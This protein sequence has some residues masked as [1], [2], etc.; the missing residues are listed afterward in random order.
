MEPQELLHQSR[1]SAGRLRPLEW[2]A[3]VVVIASAL[4]WS[5][6][7]TVAAQGR[8]GTPALEQRIA[9][10]EAKVAALEAATSLGASQIAALQAALANEVTARRAADT[11]LQSSIDAEIAVRQVGDTTLQTNIDAEA[12][13]RRAADTGLQTTTGEFLGAIEA[14]SRARESEDS[15]L[16]NRAAALENKTQYISVAGGDMFITGTN[17]NI[18]NGLGATNGNPAD[19]IST[20]PA[21]THVNGK[22]NL[23]VGYNES[24]TPEGSHNIVIGVGNSYRSFGGLLAGW[25]NNLLAPYASVTGGYNNTAAGNFS[26]VTGGYSNQAVADYSAVHG[27]NGNRAAGIGSTVTAG[28]NNQAVSNY[29]AVHGGN[30]NRATGFV[31]SLLGGGNQTQSEAWTVLLNTEAGPVKVT[32]YK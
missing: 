29:S 3:V 5:R 7:T 26:A 24:G 10:L 1:R 18:R 27:G 4:L 13:A 30:N 12:A 14:E 21:S 16:Q 9:A 23:I 8:G 28:L 15:T 31:G 19:P 32:G 17:L 2:L 22:G 25:F 6:P 11:M 20:N